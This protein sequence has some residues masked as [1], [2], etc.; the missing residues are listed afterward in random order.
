MGKWRII[1]ALSG[2]LWLLFGA[3]SGHNVLHGK[4][5]EYFIKA[6][7]YHIVH[8]LALFWL[9]GMP[10]RGWQRIAILWLVGILFFSGSLYL[11]SI[12]SLPLEWLVPVGGTSLLS[13]WLVLIVMLWRQETG[14]NKGPK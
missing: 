3:L 8:T 6:H 2:F 12:F 11:M 13:G 1:A 14:R 10:G 9:S 5:Q 4:A 7:E